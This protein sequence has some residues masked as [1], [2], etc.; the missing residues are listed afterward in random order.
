MPLARRDW[1][2]LLLRQIFICVAL[3]TGPLVVGPPLLLGQSASPR[4]AAPAEA[5]RAADAPSTDPQDAGTYQQLTRVIDEHFA[6]RDLPGLAVLYAKDGEVAYQKMVGFADVAGNVPMSEDKVGRLNSVS[7]WVAAIVSLQ[8]VEQ[9]KLQLAAT[10]RS[11]IADL[12]EH[13]TS[14]LR[15][16]LACRSGIRHYTGQ[17]SPESP[18][19]WMESQYDTAQA[20]APQ[21]W[22]DPL[23]AAVGKYHY[24][25]HGYTILGACLEK[26]FDRPT[27]EIIRTQLSEPLD[28]PTLAEERLADGNPARMRLYTPSENGNLEVKPRNSTWKV[29]GGG[30]ESSPRDLLKLGILLGDG[31]IIARENVQLLMTRLDPEDSYCLGC[32]HTVEHGEQVMAKSGSFQGSNAYIWLVPERRMVM[33]IMANRDQADVTGLGLKLRSIV[34]ADDKDANKAPR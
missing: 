25:T 2:V 10:A 3:A 1:L 9:G 26:A 23:A 11:Q 32:N 31:R 14:T 34:L 20:A 15:D 13:H 21:F 18:R 27:R 29:W 24:S 28:L 30:I 5:A 33:V 19:D 16:L 12:P 7:K 4:R 17:T 6:R 22:H 8:A